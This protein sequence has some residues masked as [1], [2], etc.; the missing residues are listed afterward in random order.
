MCTCCSPTAGDAALQPLING[1][2]KIQ[3]FAQEHGLCNRLHALIWLI[4]TYYIPA[5]MYASQIWATPFLKQG[6]EMDNPLLKWIIATLKRWLGVRDTTPSWS[7]LRECGLESL[8]FN[9]F[10][11]AIRL[12]NSFTQHNS[13][14]VR[15]ILQADICLSS[16]SCDCWSSHIIN[17]MDGLHNASQFKDNIRNCKPIHLRQFVIDLRSRQVHDWTQFFGPTPRQ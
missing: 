5:A 8:Q 14:M 13:T 2:F 9:W 6:K 16:S 7:V 17:A 3:R 12:Y 1:T 11:A 15:K 4:K 10:R